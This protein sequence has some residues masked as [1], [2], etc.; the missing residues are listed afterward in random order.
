M[1]NNVKMIDKSQNSFIYF[2][3][4]IIAI[5][6]T[7]LFVLEMNFKV[8]TFSDKITKDP[9]NIDEQVFVYNPKAETPKE[10]FKEKTK[11]VV[12]NNVVKNAPVFKATKNEVKDDFI[13]ETKTSEEEPTKNNVET[14]QNNNTKDAI[15][16]NEATKVNEIKDSFSVE[17]LPRFAVC[18]NV[19]KEQQQACFEEQLQKEVGRN[20]I[21]PNS[22]LENNNEGL[23]YLHFVIDEY[24]N[25][26]Q[27]EAVQNNR[28]SKEMKLAAEKAMKKLPKII[29]A[30]IGTKA[31]KIKYTVP[32][33]FKIAK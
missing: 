18:A 33:K 3:I 32:V 13:K 4:G 16:N 2:Q 14:D 10:T 22:D 5:L 24:G 15:N 25:F 17:Y 21:Y 11:V 6:V 20:L 8:N 27:I 31:V 12:K 29:P 19:S 7:T 9:I 23:V 30:K 28:S 1:K 26:T